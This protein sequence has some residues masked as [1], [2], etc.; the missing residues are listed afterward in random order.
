MQEILSF[1]KGAVSTKD[2]I[3]V[4]TN[5]HFSNGRIQG[6][7]G[8][9]TIDAPLDLGG[10]NITVPAVPFI[11]A[12][13]ACGGQP[14]LNITAAGKLTISASKFRSTLPPSEEG[15]FPVQVFEMEGAAVS[16]DVAA[17]VKVLRRV[18]PFVADDASRPWACGCLF[19]DG[20]IYATNNVAI[21][22]VPWQGPEGVS[23]NLPSFAVDELLRIGKDPDGF[24][25]TDTSVTFCYDKGERWMRSQLFTVEWPDV[26][27]FFTGETYD[28]VPDNLLHAVEQVLPFCQDAKFPIITL[29]D[30]G[31]HTAEGDMS[32]SVGGYALPLSKYRAETLRL[33]LQHATEADFSAYPD[34]IPFRGLNGLEG[35]LVGV[36]L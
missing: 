13:E 23:F 28:A 22:R 34:P 15:S 17:L 2:L 1:V 33:A 11:K 9:V 12:V 31:V 24:F 8:R 7:N 6:G 36:S 10:I 25:H 14:K 16:N 4:L 32:A 35:C 18:R 19:K 3:P 5:F 29:N 21:V 27:R 20:Y 30:T 26:A